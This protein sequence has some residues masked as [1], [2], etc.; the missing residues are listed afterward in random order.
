M[1]PRWRA[2][3]AMALLG[4]CG[5]D[6]EVG[7]VTAPIDRGNIQARVTATGTVQ[8]TKTVLIG[9]Q[10][11]GRIQDLYVDFNSKVTKGQVLARLDPLLLQASLDQARANLAAAQANLAG[12]QAVARDAARQHARTQQ[13]AAGLLVAQAEAETAQSSAEAAQ[14]RVTASHGA[15]ALAQAAVEQAKLQ[16]SYTAIV[17]PI[18]GI[19]ISRSVDVGQTVAA[20]LQAPTL[21]TLAEDLKKMQVE[22]S[23]AEADIGKIASE[24]GAIFTVDAFPG[25]TFAGKVRQVRSA[26]QTI[27]NV[28]TYTVVIDVDNGDFALRP[29]MTANVT[30]VYAD[31]AD[32]LRVPN[33]ALRFRPPDAAPSGKQVNS[34]KTV[35]V[36]DAG[37]AKPVTVRVGIS[38][39]VY[40]EVV[41]GL[42]EGDVAI[43]EQNGGKKKGHGYRPPIGRPL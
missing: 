11:S 7:Y 14:A 29:G 21:F 19:V 39:G 28:V 4:G 40:T 16:L 6:P 9:S 2:A 30:F 18:D 27:Q 25:R 42:T 17:S 23:V 26:P 41:N 37:T 10:V 33:A 38:D 31:K 32:V 12:A 15:V 22:A 20:S 3:W 43:T 5:G 1:N 36:L 8:P 35:F 24:M 13:L 34:E